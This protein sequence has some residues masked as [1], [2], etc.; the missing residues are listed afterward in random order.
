M[1]SELLTVAYESFKDLVLGLLCKLIVYQ[2]LLHSFFLLH[3]LFFRFHQPP[4][5]VWSHVN[6]PKTFPRDVILYLPPSRAI[7]EMVQDITVP[8]GFC[9]LALYPAPAIHLLLDHV[10]F[11][12]LKV[13]TEFPLKL[14]TSIRGLILSLL[15]TYLVQLPKVGFIQIEKQ[16][17]CRMRS[18]GSWMRAHKEL[19][20]PPPSEYLTVFILE[21]TPLFPM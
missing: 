9:L 13:S 21:C 12:F 20:Q 14:L 6:V 8:M 4:R 3:R 15:G 5:S 7:L 1:T 18:S 16:T 17:R 19:H 10:F 2:F 11:F